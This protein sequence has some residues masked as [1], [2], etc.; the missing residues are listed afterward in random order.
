MADLAFG[1]PDRG[2]VVGVGVEP[3][4]RETD[5]TRS[6][7]EREVAARTET[8]V[9]RTLGQCCFSL[10]VSAKQKTLTAAD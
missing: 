5:V 7:D 2:A 6:R 1:C 4:R 8:T 3:G 10:S 9:V